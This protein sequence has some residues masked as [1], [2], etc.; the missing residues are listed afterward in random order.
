MGEKLAK[1]TLLFSFL[2]FKQEDFEKL[3]EK[4]FAVLSKLPSSSSDGTFAGKTVI[5]K[6]GTFSSYSGLEQNFSDTH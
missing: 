4:K 5:R 2:D 3:G 1:F 6:L